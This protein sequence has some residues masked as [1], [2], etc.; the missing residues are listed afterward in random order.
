MKTQISIALAAFALAGPAFAQTYSPQDTPAASGTPSTPRADRDASAGL[1]RG[2]PQ[3]QSTSREQVRA[4]LDCARASGELAELN[5]EAYDP[6]RAQAA[7]A[8]GANLPACQGLVTPTS[9]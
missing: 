6:V 3:P 8:R 4:E 9:R 2:T 1:Q 7:R 5:H